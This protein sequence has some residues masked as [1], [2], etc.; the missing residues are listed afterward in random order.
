MLKEIKYR[1]TITSLYQEHIKENQIRSRL[2]WQE[3]RVQSTH[4]SLYLEKSGKEKNYNLK[5]KWTSK[6]W[7]K[8]K[9][10]SSTEPDT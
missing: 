3:E 7:T 5:W 6:L 4:Y 2:K 10:Y 9:L 1:K 8:Q